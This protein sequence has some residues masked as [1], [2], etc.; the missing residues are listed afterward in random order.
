MIFVLIPP[1]TTTPRKGYEMVQI[2][3][4]GNKTTW[5]LEEDTLHGRLRELAKVF[6]YHSREEGARMDARFM[7]EVMELQTESLAQMAEQQEKEMERLRRVERE[8]AELR[9]EFKTYMEKSAAPA[10]TL[11]KPALRGPSAKKSSPDSAP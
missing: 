3:R 9:A 2:R 1:Q 6:N 10:G 8:L 7:S 11:E 4:Q 5:V